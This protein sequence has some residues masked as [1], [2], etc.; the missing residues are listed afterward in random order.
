MI[1]TLVN[2]ITVAIGSS[3]GL[4]LRDKL[5]QPLIKAVFSALGLFTILIGIKTAFDTSDLF[6]VVI[7]LVIGAVIGQALRLEERLTATIDKLKTKQNPSS[8][9]NDRFAE[10]LVTAFIL[11]CVGAMTF[12]GCLNEGLKGDRSTILTKAIMDLFSSVALAS[13]FGRGVLFSIIPL[14]LYQGG[15]T[16]GAQWLAPFLTT[17]IQ[18]VI[19]GCGGILLI[20]LGLNILEVTKLKIINL[21]PSLL[22]APLF[23]TY[24]PKLMDVTNGL[25]DSLL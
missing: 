2:V 3:V 7:S 25:F 10:G 23:A 12:I 6:S 21:A 1:G 18:A 20:G 17:E 14:L 15:L 19:L 13:A 22:L 11:F 4:I 24:I 9:N 8:K 16:L 5:P